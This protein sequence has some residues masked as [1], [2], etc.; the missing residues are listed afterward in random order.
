MRLPRLR[1]TGRRLALV[2]TLGLI[3]LVGLYVVL[4]IPFGDAAK[5]QGEWSVV[6]IEDTGVPV[7][8]P[9]LKT[10]QYIFDGYRTIVRAREA[11]TASWVGRLVERYFR[12]PSFRLD[13]SATPKAIDLFLPDGSTM[14]GIYELDGDRLKI[15]FRKPP[16]KADHL[17][18]L[19]FSD[20]GTET[21]L[22][23][24]DRDRP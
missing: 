3:V 17:R 6:S 4:L 18:P 7:E 19:R 2:A 5:L 16:G 21:R 1:L 20:P 13:P 14:R 11:P 22:V 23:I 12:S 9:F 10:R 24:L 8:E 15:C